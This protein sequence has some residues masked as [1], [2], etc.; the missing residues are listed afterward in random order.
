MS[1]LRPSVQLDAPAAPVTTLP[2]SA[3]GSSTRPDPAVPAILVVEDDMTLARELGDA[4]AAQGRAVIHA[5]DAVQAR[6]VL[7]ANPAIPV[8]IADLQLPGEDGLHL[9]RSLRQGGGAAPAVILI[10]AQATIEDVEAALRAGVADFLRK[11]FSVVEVMEAVEAALTQAANRRAPAAMT[12][13][14][15][16]PERGSPPP[17][18]PAV[19]PHQFQAVPIDAARFE[20]RD[21]ATV[22]DG[23]RNPLNAISCALELLEAGPTTDG[24]QRFIAVIRDGLDR[25]IEAVELVEELCRLHQGDAPAQVDRDLDLDTLIGVRQREIVVLAA[26]KAVRLMPPSAP[27]QPALRVTSCAGRVLQLCAAVGLQAARPNWDLAIRRE[28]ADAAEPWAVASVLVQPAGSA[29]SPPPGAVFV[30]TGTWL[31]RPQETLRLT[32]A[33]QIAALSGGRLTTWNAPDGGL[34]LRLAL[35]IIGRGLASAGG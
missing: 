17:M 8:V 29:F 33:R 11:P 24:N 18:P 6:S 3:P 19:Y 28:P 4:L 26:N 10:T 31:S 35:P 30:E 21:M 23:L 12:S 7:A 13:C 9:A 22:S 2:L 14:S 34:A 25:T 16:L 15:G 20:A 27:R 5:H 1:A 32:L